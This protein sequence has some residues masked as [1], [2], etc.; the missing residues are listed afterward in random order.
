M[1][2]VVVAAFACA[3]LLPLLASALAVQPP[4]GINKDFGSVPDVVLPVP[5]ISGQFW[6][7]L[8]SICAPVPADSILHP[9][10][11]GH[12]PEPEPPPPPPPPP[13]S[14]MVMISEIMYSP[15]GTDAGHE[16]IEIVND[17]GEP[18]NL[19]SWKFTDNSGDHILT[20]FAGDTIVPP[21]DFVI[22]ADNPALFM[23]D[24]PG[25]AGTIFDSVVSLSNAGETLMLKNGAGDIVDDI[26][27]ASTDGA[28]GDGN[29]LHRIDDGLEAAAPT[30]GAPAALP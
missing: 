13:S 15:D 16:W 28:D 5:N 10:R 14:G 2:P 30:P 20:L 8:G 7:M 11:P 23:G 3:L 27:Y 26:T 29:S 17:T 4:K 12:C 22:I 1:R 6:F 25:F 19:L 24:W 9:L 21:G 18:V